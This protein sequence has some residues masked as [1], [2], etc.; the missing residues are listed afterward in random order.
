MNQWRGTPFLAVLGH[1]GAV[2]IEKVDSGVMTVQLGKHVIL[3]Y[4]YCEECLE[5]FTRHQQSLLRSP[6]SVKR[7][8]QS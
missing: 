3:S 4:S 8:N 6:E 7:L 2:N 5:C 1:E